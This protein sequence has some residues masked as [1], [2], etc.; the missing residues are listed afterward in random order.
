MGQARRAKHCT[1][2][3]VQAHELKREE[4]KVTFPGHTVSGSFAYR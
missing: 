1:G 2:V 3:G 4:K